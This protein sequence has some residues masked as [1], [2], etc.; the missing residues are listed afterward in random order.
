MRTGKK[1]LLLLGLLGMLCFFVLPSVTVQAGSLEDSIKQKQDA[2]S[3]AQEEKKKLQSGLSDIK[4]MVKELEKSKNN[5]QEYV[6]ELDKQLLTLGEKIEELEKQITEKK[7]EIE[8]AKKDLESAEAVAAKQYADMKLRLRYMYENDQGEGYLMALLTADSFAGLLNQAEYIEKLSAYDNRKLLE[9]KQNVEYMQLCKQT[10]EEE[11]AVLQETEEALAAEQESVNTLI[12]EKEKEIVAFQGDIQNK[13]AAMEDYEAEIAEQNATI[14]ALEK[15]VAED[16]AK[17]AEQNRIKYD[18]GM[19]QFPCPGYTRVSSEYGNRLHP[20][21]GVNKFHN[22]V[23][24]AAPTGTPILAAYDG[25][26]VGASYNSSMGNYVMIDHGDGL[27]TVYMHAS[28]LYVSNGQSVSKGDTIAAV[29]S[30][31]RS[32][33]PHLHFSVRLNGSYVS[34]WNYLK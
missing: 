7:E 4:S 5:L 34:P 10:L 21:L 15:A 14:A 28:K 23:D 29:G 20:T 18:G 24:L 13:E 19:F 8:Q 27:Y 25:R 22:G 16:K 12:N 26:V 33:G 3:Q 17:L 9:Y 6:V 2:I 1:H 32:T 31:G 30:T 11:E